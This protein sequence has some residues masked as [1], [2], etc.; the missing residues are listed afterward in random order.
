MNKMTSQQRKLVYLIGI[1]VLL[2]PIIQLSLPADG[3]KT[4][5]GK[6]KNPGGILSQLRTKYDLG[7]SDLGDV[8]PSGAAINL[9]LLGMRGIAV[10]ILWIELDKQKDMK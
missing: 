8:D 4:A 7:E 9:V 3:T 5:E 6:P 1:I 2:A 10:N